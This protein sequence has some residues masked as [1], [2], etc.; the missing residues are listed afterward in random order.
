I[1][2]LPVVGPLVVKTVV[3]RFARTLSILLTS[4]IPL[5]RALETMEDVVGNT[6][7]AG[8]IAEARASI[9]EGERMSP[10]LA[11][12]SF[13]TPMAVSMISVGE[14]SGALDT[15]LEK[16]ATFYEAEV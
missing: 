15:M 3:A 4:G 9:K 14:E 1:L 8:D 2:R 12:S 7:A 10:I 5:M 16:L 11:R 13:F 6:V